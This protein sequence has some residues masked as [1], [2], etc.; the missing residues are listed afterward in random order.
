MSGRVAVFASGG[1][2]NLQALL[3]HF[4]GG[5]GAGRGE[6]ASVVSDRTD[7]GALERAERS[8]VPTRV[9]TV[10]GRSERDVARQTLTA[11]EEERIDVVAL[12]GYL[13][14]VPSEVVE[15]FRG[16]MVNIHP[17]LLPSFGGK[18]MYGRRIHEAVLEAGCRVTGATVHL[19]DERYDTGMILAQWPVPVREDDSPETLAERV[20]RIEH[21]LYP[22]VVEA[23]LAAARR[24]EPPTPLS[25]EDADVFRLGA[26]D[27]PGVEVLRHVMGIGD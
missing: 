23:V 6:V 4:G 7:A 2:T 25:A 26:D 14:L 27:A 10:A 16:R 15:R 18:G 17:A 9:I 3:D 8:G 22:V 1:G 11:L 12:A 20:L 5:P 24:H 19:V 21:R 13:R